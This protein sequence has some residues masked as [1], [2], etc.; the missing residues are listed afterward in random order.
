LMCILHNLKF[1][2][3]LFVHRSKLVLFLH[4]VQMVIY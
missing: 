1:G 3:E 4:D 2:I